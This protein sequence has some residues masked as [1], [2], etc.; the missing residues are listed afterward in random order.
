MKFN[1]KRMIFI[2]N[3]VKVTNTEEDRI[4]Q[5]KIQ[6]SK[7]DGCFYIVEYQRNGAYGVCIKGDMKDVEDDIIIPITDAKKFGSLLRNIIDT[8]EFELD[9]EDNKVVISTKKTFSE[10]PIYEELEEKKK[11]LK[12][13]RNSFQ[14]EE[15]GKFANKLRYSQREGIEEDKPDGIAKVN[16]NSL[17]LPKIKSNFNGAVNMSITDDSL[18][19]SVGVS[20]KKKEKY[21]ITRIIKKES[22]E[23]PTYAQGQCSITIMNTDCL[24][25]LSSYDG[26]TYLELKENVPLIIKREFDKERVGICY[27]VSLLEEETIE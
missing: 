4:S 1:T 2:N 20:K 26:F 23:D 12:N 21:N 19:I 5:Y 27:M 8:E 24:D 14:T 10:F 18:V 11:A 16:L 3:L 13:L 7:K 17:K 6:V 9:I 22:K 25:V 15:F